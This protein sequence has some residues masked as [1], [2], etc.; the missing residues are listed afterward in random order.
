MKKM[1][2]KFR[3][4]QCIV[5]LG[6]L[7]LLLS[8][9]GTRAQWARGL[10]GAGEGLQGRYYDPHFYERKQQQEW[11]HMQQRLESEM[12]RNKHNHLSFCRAW[13]QHCY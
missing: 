8:G 5:K 13:P 4:S 12:V 7:G 6:L 9:C 1:P 10:Q 3:L 11:Q 2:R